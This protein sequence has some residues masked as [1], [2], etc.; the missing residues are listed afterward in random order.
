M[1]KVIYQTIASA[2]ADVSNIKHIDL[3]QQQTNLAEEEQPFATPAVF[4]EFDS[5]DWRQH[6][7]GVREASVSITLHI[8]TDSRVGHWSDTVQVFDLIDRIAA[9]LHG[10]HTTTP[11]G[12]VMDALTLERSTTDHNFDELQDNQETYACHITDRSAYAI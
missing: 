12:S 11:D 7:H 5:I 8:V 2:L 9:R 4:V 1:R 10:L 3:W 6:L